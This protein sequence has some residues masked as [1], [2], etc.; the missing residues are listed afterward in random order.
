MSKK[1]SYNMVWMDMEMTGLEPERD[2]I[3]EIATVITDKN[4]NILEVGPCLV[5]HHG[6][7]KLKKMDKWNTEHHTASGLIERVRTSKISTKKAEELTLEF[8]RKYARP[9]TAPLCGN[10]IGQD[11][12]FLY[13]YM[14]QLSDY[15][16][17][18]SIDVTTVKELARRWYPDRSLGPKKK[19]VHLALSDIQESID[20][21][22]YYREH[23]FVRNL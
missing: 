2:V 16:H 21:L 11:R 7:A 8:I 5:V 13:K 15:L 10:S 19:K 20:E 4:L 23:F 12:R 3:L 6:E 9:R 14:P 18:R 1:S 17:F 22:R